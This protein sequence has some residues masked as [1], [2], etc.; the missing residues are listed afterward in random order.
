[1]GEP[2][3]TQFEDIP[4]GP[5]TSGTDLLVVEVETTAREWMRGVLVPDYV[6][7]FVAG[8]RDAL[9]AL[10]ASRPQLVVSEVD[11]GDG[12]GFELC[13]QMRRLPAL[14]ELPILLYTARASTADKVRGFQAGADDYVVKPIDGR[15]LHARLR[16][17]QRIKSIEPPV[18]LGDHF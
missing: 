6:L 13:R 11:L 4:I 18:L 15:T 9:A 16:L 14:R 7:H 1:M 10:A 5:R 12:D 2:K 3:R 17:L 8:L